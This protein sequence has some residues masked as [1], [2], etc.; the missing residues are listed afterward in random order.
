MLRRIF[1]TKIEEVVGG[2][3]DEFHI[4]YSSANVIRVIKSR[5]VRWVG[6][7]TRMVRDRD[8]WRALL[9]TVMN[10]WVL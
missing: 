2:W 4:F 5:G 9:N 6:H 10:H 1:V 8:Q 7:V 3:S